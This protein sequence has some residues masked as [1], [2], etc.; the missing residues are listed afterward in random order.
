MTGIP[1]KI[2]VAFSVTNCICHDQRVMKIAT[3][4]NSFGCD[5]LI[6]G[7]RMGECCEKDIVPFRVKRFRMFFKKGFLF[8][9]FYNLR[10]FFFLL[11]HKN[12]L[13]VA[14]DL[15]TLLPNF[16]ISRLKRL[17][18]VYDSHEY[19]TGVPAIQN[20]PLVKWVWKTIERFV[21]PHLKYIMTVSDSIAKRYESEYSI[22]PVTI[23]NFSPNPSER[24]KYSKSELGINPGNLLLILQGAGINIDRGG[25]ELIEAVNITEGVSLLIVGSGDI[26]QLLKD[27]VRALDLG[28]R[29]K[30]IPK[31][32]WFELMKYTRSADAGISVDRC[33]NLNHEFSLPNKVFD[34]IS[35]GIP[36]VASDLCEI[37]KLLVKHNCG[38]I[39]P[40][41]SPAEIS[42]AIKKIRDDSSLLDEL[43]QNAI[44]AS[45]SVNWE[46]ES[47]KVRAFYKVILEKYFD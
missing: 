2:R 21:F 10:L 4:I 46:V 39:I 43:K 41:V 13:L 31:I 30:F 14:N 11:F 24:S 12:D 25:E 44:I 33:T 16:L 6:I 9:K 17:P 45:K 34:Y 3:E 27:K 23:R 7:R 20:R 36:V 47:I 37:K 22:R 32:P 28:D 1:Y 5:T 29:V 15:D 35:S 38:I 18:L 26:L 40:E 19:F 42:K 8:Y